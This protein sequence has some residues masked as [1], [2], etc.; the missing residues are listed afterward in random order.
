MKYSGRDLLL[1]GLFTAI[2]LVFPILFHAVGLG[3]SF[4]PMFYPIIMAGFLLATPVA[5]LVG[6]LSPLISAIVTGM[7]PFFPPIAIIMMI[8]GIVLTGLPALLYQKYKFN[9]WITLFFTILIDRMILLAAIFITSKWLELPEQVWGIVKLIESIP[10]I[11]LIFIVIPPM[12]KTMNKKIK[13]MVLI[14]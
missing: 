12:V 3:S 11:I 1:G 5:I 14:D 4:L 8:E 10:G 6:I 2:S 7:P 13:Y 9:I